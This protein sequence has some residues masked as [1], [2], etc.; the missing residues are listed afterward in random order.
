MDEYVSKKHTKEREFRGCGGHASLIL[1]EDVSPPNVSPLT[2]HLTIIYPMI[3]LQVTRKCNFLNYC[4]IEVN[5]VSIERS[6]SVEAKSRWQC[7]HSSRILSTNLWFKIITKQM[8][9]ELHFKV[10]RMHEW[11]KGGTWF[12][13]SEVMPWT[14]N[15]QRSTLSWGTEGV[16]WTC[17]TYIDGAYFSLYVSPLELHHTII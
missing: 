16:W 1:M 11:M 2:P 6:W 7:R 10:S 14:S 5:K 12:I 15:F 13:S 4:P 9:L 8:I 3:S 17:P